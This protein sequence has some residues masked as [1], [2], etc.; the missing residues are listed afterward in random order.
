M[1]RNMTSENE[2]LRYQLKRT[3]FQ[4]TE[5]AEQYQAVVEQLGL[6]RDHFLCLSERIVQLHDELEKER[7]LRHP[8]LSIDIPISGETALEAKKE[9]KA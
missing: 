1:A 5:Q 6:E 8:Q 3:R 9:E 4:L 2:K 7:K